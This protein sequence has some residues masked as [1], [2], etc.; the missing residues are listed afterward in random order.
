MDFVAVIVMF[1][2][3]LPQ[4]HGMS[5]SVYSSSFPVDFHP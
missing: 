2:A 1:Y 5:G 4:L 3:S